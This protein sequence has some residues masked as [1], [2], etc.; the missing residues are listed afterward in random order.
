[1]LPQRTIHAACAGEGKFTNKERIQLA[2]SEDHPSH[3]TC[4]SV[5]LREVHGE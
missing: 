5:L 3:L 1:M 4:T 2:P